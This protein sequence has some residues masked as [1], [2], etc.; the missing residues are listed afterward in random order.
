MEH[1]KLTNKYGLIFWASLIAYIC[2]FIGL[3]LNTQYITSG[4]NREFTTGQVG[5]LKQV[6]CEQTKGCIEMKYE[7]FL[8]LDKES[9]KYFVQAIVKVKNKAD[10]N[11]AIFNTLLD[12]ARDKLPIYLNKRLGGIEVIMLNGQQLIKPVDNRPEWYKSMSDSFPD[13]LHSLN[14]SVAK[15]LN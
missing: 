9:N 1:L 8:R 5:K 7:R 2:V 13:T 11:P 12:G 14:I 6:A 15:A 10:F 4:L 3:Y